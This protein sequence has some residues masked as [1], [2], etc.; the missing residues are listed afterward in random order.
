MY[1]FS[2]A[3]LAIL[4]LCFVGIFILVVYPERCQREIVK[5]MMVK[6]DINMLYSAIND[7]AAMVGKLPDSP[8]NLSPK[9]ISKLPK[10]AWGSEYIYER[11]HNGEFRVYSLGSDGKKGD[12]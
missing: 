12:E 8:E 6:A 9:Y 5:S 10:D 1:K 7:Y 2:C 4:I 3:V 11:G